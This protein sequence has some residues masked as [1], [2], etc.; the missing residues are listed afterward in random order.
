VL[1]FEAYERGGERHP[2]DDVKAA[3]EAWDASAAA[4]AA[5]VALCACC[6]NWSD[7]RRAAEPAIIA[8]VCLASFSTCGGDDVPGREEVGDG[9]SDEDRGGGTGTGSVLWSLRNCRIRF[10]CGEVP[11]D[12]AIGVPHIGLFTLLALLDVVAGLGRSVFFND[13]V[14][15]NG[16]NMSKVSSNDADGSLAESEREPCWRVWKFAGEPAEGFACGLMGEIPN[17]PLN[18]DMGSNESLLSSLPSV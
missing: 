9:R 4:S 3:K 13:V 10:A 1:V 7:R 2:E 6:F 5:S 18:V 14:V 17:V 11:S 8:A 12:L 15:A 16:D